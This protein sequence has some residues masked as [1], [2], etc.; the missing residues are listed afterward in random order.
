MAAL[1]IVA[2]PAAAQAQDPWVGAWRLNLAK[3]KYE[4]ANLAPKSQTI[5]QDAVAGGG[6]KTVVDAVDGWV[7]VRCAVC[8]D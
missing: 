8:L 7:A 4:P 6:T 1:A 5:R 2:L 3:S